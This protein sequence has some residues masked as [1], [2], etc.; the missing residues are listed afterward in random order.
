MRQSMRLKQGVTSRVQVAAHTSVS[1]LVHAL[2][3]AVAPSRSRSQARRKWQC[4]VASMG[5]GVCQT[6]GGPKPRRREGVVK[7]RRNM[8]MR[9]LKRSRRRWSRR[10]SPPPPLLSSRRFFWQGTS[11]ARPPVIPAKALALDHRRRA[12]PPSFASATRRRRTLGESNSK[13]LMPAP[14]LPS[15]P[16]RAERGA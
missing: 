12:R 6:R 5:N 11:R 10:R 16:R 4:L 2:Y 7:E 3:C 14:S 9:T 1:A 13:A 15:T 8:K